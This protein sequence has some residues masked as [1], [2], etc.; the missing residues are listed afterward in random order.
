VIEG[1]FCG[2]TDFRRVA[3]G[4]PLSTRFRGNVVGKIVG[5]K[6][7]RA[8]GAWF[9]TVGALIGSGPTQAQTGPAHRAMERCVDRV[10]SRLAQAKAPEREVGRAVTSGCDGPLRAV[11]AEAMKTGEAQM[12][13]SVDACMDI[14]RKTAADE[15]RQ[16]YRARVSR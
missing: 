6:M 2:Q 1:M 16:A 14:A 10:L 4:D 11:L 13:A 3:T 5:K 12:C 7:S 9:L 15:A 8:A